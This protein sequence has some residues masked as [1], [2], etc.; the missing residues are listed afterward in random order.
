M[1]FPDVTKSSLPLQGTGVI[2]NQKKAIDKQEV[3]KKSGKMTDGHSTSVKNDSFYLNKAREE[4]TKQAIKDLGPGG[5]EEAMSFPPAKARIEKTIEDK[6]KE[7]KAADKKVT[8]PAKGVNHND[9]GNEMAN[10]ETSLFRSERVVLVYQSKNLKRRQNQQRII[11]RKS[12]ESLGMQKTEEAEKKEA[13]QKPPP[14]KEEIAVH[15]IAG[16]I[17]STETSFVQGLETLQNGAELMKKSDKKSVRQLGEEMDASL[18][19]LLASAREFK[20]ELDKAVE[21][22]K[23][24]K[25]VKIDSQAISQAYTTHGPAYF[26]GI[27]EYALK[28][29]HFNKEV[30]DLQ[31]KY[32]KTMAQIKTQMEVGVAKP[33]TSIQDYTIMPIQRG[34]R[35][36]LL[37]GDLT[38]NTKTFNDSLGKTLESNVTS[39]KESADSINMEIAKQEAS[40]IRSQV[41]ATLS[42]GKMSSQLMKG[43]Q[44]SNSNAIVKEYETRLQGNQAKADEAKALLQQLTQEEKAIENNFLKDN[45]QYVEISKQIKELNSLGSLSNDQ[46]AQ[47]RALIDAT[48][49]YGQALGKLKEEVSQKIEETRDIILNN[50]PFRIEKLAFNENNP[51]EKEE[52]KLAATQLEMLFSNTNQKNA[53]LA[54]DIKKMVE[55]TPKEKRP[56][57]YK[58]LAKSAIALA[59]KGDIVSAL[60]VVSAIRTSELSKKELKALK[61]YNNQLNEI[62]NTKHIEK[63]KMYAQENKLTSYTYPLAS[64]GKMG[65]DLTGALN[66][67]LNIESKE[68]E[69]ILAQTISFH[70]KNTEEL[71]K[72]P[73]LFF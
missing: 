56:D 48:V 72:E 73:H 66:N 23:D 59:E 40:V 14:S 35:H 26:S 27:K 19:P 55:E 17:Q 70:Q 7:L 11:D 37:L 69:N 13:L 36:V 60:T 67:G 34:P 43:I 65:A 50:A 44:K 49:P 58:G 20:A 21:R 4:V 63:L 31:A 2:E 16:E 39:V 15:Y 46:E 42:K 29:E 24:G 25:V 33:L 64:I 54:K 9:M 45:P 41:M 5:Y 8:R 3:K 6:A 12:R 18:K 53:S 61:K 10:K 22:D 30:T 28:Y 71:N 52:A 57:M 62:F 68:T 32:P 1:S 51:V 38:K 47:R